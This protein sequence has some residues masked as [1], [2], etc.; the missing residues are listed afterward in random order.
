M[1]NST[2]N[3]ARGA[4][5]GCG[6]GI[7]I[8][9]LFGL[10]WLYG[11][12]KFDHAPDWAFYA[13]YA[14]AAALVFAG[15]MHIRSER[16]SGAKQSKA[17]RVAFL[18]VFAL[19]VAAIIAA[20]FILS[21]WH[22]QQYIVAVICAIVGLHFLP[23]AKIFRR[24]SYYATGLAMVAAAAAAVLLLKGTQQWICIAYSAGAIL[25][26]TALTGAVRR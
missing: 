1:T 24:P 20:V 25:W 9:A 14:A 8:G 4:T 13:A 7:C 18:I 3:E 26:L 17:V 21:H 2:Q 6:L 11:A 19:E 23:L 15:I 12:L 16:Q 10:G 5:S 22:M